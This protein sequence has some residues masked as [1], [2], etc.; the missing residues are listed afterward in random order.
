MT[1]RSQE[2][3]NG[4]LV[5]PVKRAGN[6]LTGI[7]MLLFGVPLWFIGGRY[8]VDGWIIAI[9]LLLTWLRLPVEIPAPGPWLA[10]ALLIILGLVYSW[11]EV[12]Y[13]PGR[14]WRTMSG[15]VIAATVLVNV[16]D[17]ASTILGV[18]TPP[19]NSWPIVLF[20]A[21]APPLAI[22]LGVLLTYLP[23]WLIMGA[24]KTMRSRN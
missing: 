23:E 19:A 6:V 7:A 12:R 8:T 21:S 14:K 5:A 20:V 3:D 9:N 16:T 18:M 22:F 24:I 4:E 15:G 13:R 1:I 17:F 10:L 11:V 2:M